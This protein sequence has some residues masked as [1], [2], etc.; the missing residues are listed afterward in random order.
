MYAEADVPTCS[1]AGSDRDQPLKTGEKKWTWD[2]KGKS[3][4]IGQ[5]LRGGFGGWRQKKLV[6]EKGYLQSLPNSLHI[7]TGTHSET[8]RRQCLC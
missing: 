6:G 7:A 3:S 5:G 4:V 2:G 1:T 8:K